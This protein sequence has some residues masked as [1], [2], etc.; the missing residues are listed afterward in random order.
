[1]NKAVICIIIATALVAFFMWGVSQKGL[2]EKN[3]AQKECMEEKIVE[4]VKEKEVI[5]YV[6]KEKAE[7]WSAPNAERSDL[8]KLMYED[9]L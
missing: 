2:A 6:Y 7:I 4:V 8:L 1:M 3:K 9:K 5:K